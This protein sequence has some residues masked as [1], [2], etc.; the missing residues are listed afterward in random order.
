[1]GNNKYS[2][3][4]SLPVSKGYYEYNRESKSALYLDEKEN[5]IDSL[6]TALGFFT[7]EDNLK[8]KWIAMSLHHSLYSFAISSLEHGNYKEVVS[9]GYNDDNNVYV[10]ISNHTPMKSRIVPFYME[11]NKKPAYRIEWD[12][13]DSI[14]EIK[15]KATKEK[16]KKDKLITFW[17]ALARIQDNY[18]WMR[19]FVHSKAVSI[20]DEELIKICWLSEK[21]R[22]DLTHF[23][24]KSYIIGIIDVAEAVKI[25]LRIIDSLVFE[26]NMILFMDS[27]KSQQRIKDALA[28]I[29]LKL[30]EEEEKIIKS[31]K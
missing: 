14:P 9:K 27:G 10:Q 4:D 16:K 28:E 30:K 11:Q 13:V 19:R 2:K 25:I 20:A 23:V 26:S 31:N 21:V 17:T 1:M 22:N 12:V 6:E 5:A 7:R 8:W 18:F 15:S 24:P 3:R 29:K